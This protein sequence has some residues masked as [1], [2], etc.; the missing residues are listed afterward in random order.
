M[1]LSML[2]FLS[3]GHWE[4]E[5]EIRERHADLLRLMES[6]RRAHELYE[7]ALQE[8]EDPRLSAL[9]SFMASDEERRIKILEYL[10]ATFSAPSGV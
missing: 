6:E 3:T 8:V 4:N 10:L 7:K 1:L 2:A 5:G 9:L